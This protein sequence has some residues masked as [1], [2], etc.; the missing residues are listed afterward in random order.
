MPYHIYNIEYNSNGPAIAISPILLRFI[1]C[2]EG[3]SFVAGFYCTFPCETFIFA[4]YIVYANN[5]GI[6]T[7]TG[8]INPQVVWSA[9]RGHAVHDNATVHLTSNGDLLLLDN[10]GSVAWSTNTSGRSVAGMT[11]SESG[12]LILFDHKNASVWQSFDH[13]T[14]CLLPEQPLVEG[15]KLT[16]NTSATTW[17]TTSQL[18][19][20]T[21][22]A[23]GLYAFVESNPPQLYYQ[24]TVP[25]TKT[26]N[27]LTYA[28]VANGSL[29]IFPQ[30]FPPL[31]WDGRACLPTS[32]SLQYLRFEFDGHLRLYELH[33]SRIVVKDMLQEELNDCA[34]PTVCGEYGI[35]FNGECSCPFESNISLTYFKQIYDLTSSLGCAPVTPVSCSSVKDHQLV[36]VQDVSY[37]NYLD[38]RAA[39]PKPTDEESCKQ[40]CLR[41][42][43]CKAALFQYGD[44]TSLGYCLLPSQLFS[45]EAIQS[46]KTGYNSSA[47][48]K[49][50]IAQSP[51]TS[52]PNKSGNTTS[53]TGK[54][55]RIAIILG[56]T[57][58]VAAVLLIMIIIVVVC[59]RKRLY[60]DKNEG[61]DFEQIPGMLTR[62]T[63]DRL[64][65]ATEDF[66]KKIG[67]GGFGTVFEGNIDEEKVAVKRMDQV[68]QEKK[69]FLAEVEAIG[70]I[71]HIN[72][73][74][75]IGFC[76]QGSHRLLVFEHMS[77]GSLDKWIYYKEN[78]APLD[79]HARYQIITDIAKGLAY[80]HEG[81]R[82]RIA[83][84]DIKPQNILLD[85]NFNAKVS[86]F[87]LAKL[88]D[89]DKSHVITRMRGTPG[90]LAPEWL[91]S[92]ITEKADIY[93]FGIVVMEII[94]GRKNLDC[95]Q[96]EENIHL[97]SI[98]QEKAKSG[99][100]ADMIDKHSED[101]QEHIGEVI[102]MM[103][104][105]MWCLQID[106]NRRPLMS[107][108]VKVLE[109]A[110][111]VETSID[112]NFVVTTAV[113]T[114]S[115]PR[116]PASVLSGPR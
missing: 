39:L 38:F 32:N 46:N 53:S 22:L 45:M 14:D 78:N 103:K 63:Y 102:Q 70:S 26:R 89:R 33:P 25:T 105:A 106:S 62:F 93:S 4:I 66:S 55:V 13:P 99:E 101:M 76:I 116:P 20:L 90:Y 8:T 2:Y 91:T 10:D 97:I 77:K 28:T 81:C 94:N 113:R 41:N 115:S 19:Y 6:N 86:D 72:L 104:L 31:G 15:T 109:G 56:S 12:N 74:R 49:V 17:F 114:S 48:M 24:K 100:L 21:T 7:T 40:A 65:I 30:S 95:S 44:N 47:F 88:I 9:N 42:C 5:A 87:G 52:P 51:L 67:E 71:H 96:P 27:K 84:L 11:L 35:C 79:W 54:R 29:A 37:F 43:S 112:Y 107:M 75:L 36:A 111:D 16:P 61:D 59:L 57:M 34:Y 80:L 23:D 108:V 98:L 68:G 18:Y 85:N 58:A 60:Q 50:Q 82:Q 3:L 69:E 1:P 110:L 92:H 64:R 73:V 83:H